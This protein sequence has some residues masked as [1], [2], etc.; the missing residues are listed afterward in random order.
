MIK[1]SI[2]GK[3]MS[4]TLLA[5]AVTNVDARPRWHADP[6]AGACDE[7][8]GRS[9]AL[10]RQAHRANNWVERLR[11]NGQTGRRLARAERSLA[12]AESRFTNFTGLPVPGF[13][14]VCEIPELANWVD[15]NENN[16]ILDPV[17][18][19]DQDTAEQCTLTFEFADGYAEG[20]SG[21]R[22]PVAILSSSAYHNV[23]YL[24]VTDVTPGTP[25]VPC[26]SSAG[27]YCVTIGSYTVTYTVYDPS[28]VPPLPPGNPVDAT[29]LL[30]CAAAYGCAALAVQ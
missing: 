30:S 13:G 3:V 5:V 6:S 26:D 25:I 29:E 18:T 14:P 4:V 2:L 16:S 15:A 24:D 23:T 7:L 10:C 19:V 21:E 17:L 12:R 22:E 27:Q 1:G 11:E 9:A 28:G 20:H 8:R